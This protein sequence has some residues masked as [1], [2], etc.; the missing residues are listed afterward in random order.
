MVWEMYSMSKE[1]QQA[2]MNTLL[3]QIIRKSYIIINLSFDSRSKGKN[4]WH[5]ATL[6]PI[7]VRLLYLLH[8]H[9]HK[10]C[11][12]H[13]TIKCDK[14]FPIKLVAES[15]SSLQPLRLELDL[16]L[17]HLLWSEPFFSTREPHQEERAVQQ[18]TLL[19]AL[20]P[21]TMTLQWWLN[22]FC[23][24]LNVIFLEEKPGTDT[25]KCAPK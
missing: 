20:F 25:V 9:I 11:P 14:I 2:W 10:R 22:I 15:W 18:I 21:S 5:Q 1:K 16:K 7:R 4:G 19:H 23:Q 17:F 3:I 8:I 13:G 24:Q 6:T 12:L